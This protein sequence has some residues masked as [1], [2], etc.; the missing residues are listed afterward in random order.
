MKYPPGSL[1]RSM[2][3]TG[4]FLYCR[5]KESVDVYQDVHDAKMFLDLIRT[6]YKD[7]DK[8]K[9]LRALLTVEQ[10]ED[11]KRLVK[12]IKSGKVERDAWSFKVD[13]AQTSRRQ[14]PFRENKMAR[15]ICKN[16]KPLY[17][18]LYVKKVN[19]LKPEDEY[20]RFGRA[21]LMLRADRIGFP[22]ELKDET[23]NERLSGQILKYIKGATCLIKLGGFDRVQGVVI[24]PGYSQEAIN[25][26][27]QV[28]VIILQI[29]VDKNDYRLQRI[30]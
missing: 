4:R 25:Q 10:W 28:G 1:S 21:D 6:Q 27:H 5:L 3:N 16:P 7:K 2:F 11:L 23:S 24:A 30:S 17:K 9:Y 19:E 8:R 14:L 22:I 20:G 13:T 12:V 29:H 15:I 26:L 18:S